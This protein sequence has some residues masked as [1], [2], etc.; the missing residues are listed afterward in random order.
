[1]GSL[2]VPFSGKPVSSISEDDLLEL[3]V[4]EEGES[5]E[6]DYKRLLPGKSDADR[7]EFLF[8]ISSFANT[9]GGY[10]VFGMD[11]DQGLPT[12]LPGLK[13]IN[14]DNE[15]RRLEEMA[16]DGIRPPIPGLQTVAIPLRAGTHA[17]VTG[18]PKSW[19]PPHQVTYQKAFRFYGRDS[20]GK[21]QFDVEELRSVFARSEGIAERM[22]EFRVNRISKLIANDLVAI[23]SAGGRMIMHFLP[24]SAFARASGVDLRAFG[25]GGLSLCVRCHKML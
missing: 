19:N 15:V 21:Y 14:A 11:E 17:I 10:L 1:M 24:L 5:K 8:D 25:E 6:I 4:A 12:A 9:S 3:I 23:L 22:H 16:R 2:T 20:N 7:R 18:I 13:D